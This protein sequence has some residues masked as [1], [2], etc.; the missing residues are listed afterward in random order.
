MPPVEP[1]TTIY[2]CPPEISRFLVHYGWILYTAPVNTPQMYYNNKHPGY[3]TWEQAATLQMMA[4][5]TMG[6]FS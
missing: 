2:G 3:Y 1:I 6:A 5:L 4:N